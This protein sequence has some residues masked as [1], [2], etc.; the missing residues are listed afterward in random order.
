MVRSKLNELPEKTKSGD[1][2]VK[3]LDEKLAGIEKLVSF[4]KDS[5]PTVDDVKKLRDAATALE[6]EI[7]NKK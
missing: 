5:T 7:S 2:L 4:P 3:L 6:K 1:P